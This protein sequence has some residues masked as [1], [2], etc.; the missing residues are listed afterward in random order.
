MADVHEERTVKRS[1]KRAMTCGLPILAASLSVFAV[2]STQALAQPSIQGAFGNTIQSTYPDGRQ[3]DLWLQPNGT[4]EALGRRGQRT[5]GQ[6]TVRGTQLCLSQRRPFP[7]LLSYCTPIPARFTETWN[8][9]APTGEAI[10]VDLLRGRVVG[11]K[12]PPPRR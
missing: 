4:Y 7:V 6:W 3:G 11:R 2:V 9:R 8:A 1:V 10:R 12:G 5:G